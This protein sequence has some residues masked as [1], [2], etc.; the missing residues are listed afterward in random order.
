MVRNSLR[1]NPRLESREADK[2]SFAG[3]HLTDRMVRFESWYLV[4]AYAS[5]WLLALVY[6]LVRL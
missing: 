3:L 2:R 4:M 5:L 6:V 1:D